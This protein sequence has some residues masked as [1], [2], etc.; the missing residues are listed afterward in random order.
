MARTRIVSSIVYSP[1]I[2]TI[3]PS[4]KR[5]SPG[6][7][8]KWPTSAESQTHHVCHVQPDA[9]LPVFETESPLW[10]TGQHA[11][12]KEQLTGTTEKVPCGCELEVIGSIVSSDSGRGEVLVPEDDLLSTLRSL[13]TIPPE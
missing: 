13:Q 10:I 8:C 5:P 7:S 2:K 9:T 4:V 3:Q 6:T 1:S 11:K 12:Q